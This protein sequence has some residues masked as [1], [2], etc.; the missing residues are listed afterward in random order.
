[1]NDFKLK[2]DQH[3]LEMIELMV[4][5]LD[6]LEIQ[7]RVSSCFRILNKLLKGELQLN[8]ISTSDLKQMKE[9]IRFYIETVEGIFEPNIGFKLLRVLEQ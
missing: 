3:E 9:D 1:M 2:F 6:G 8:Q 5:A 4:E 7:G